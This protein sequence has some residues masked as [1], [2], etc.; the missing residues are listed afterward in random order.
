[1]MNYSHMPEMVSRPAPKTNRQLAPETL[2]GPTRDPTKKTIRISRSCAESMRKPQD[3]PHQPVES[4]KRTP[5]QT[6]ASSSAALLPPP[7]AGKRSEKISRPKLGSTQSDIL[8]VPDSPR[9]QRT[10]LF[11]SLTDPKQSTSLSSSSLSPRIQPSLSKSIQRIPKLEKTSSR[12]RL[13]NHS[14]KP[15]DT[16]SSNLR[17]QRF[18]EKESPKLD[19]TY[20]TQ[21]V[22]QNALGGH[23]KESDLRPLQ[24]AHRMAMGRQTQQQRFNAA[25]TGSVIST[26]ALTEM[27]ANHE[28]TDMLENEQVPLDWEDNMTI[29]SYPRSDMPSRH[30]QHHVPLHHNNQS[31]QVNNNPPTNSHSRDRTIS[32]P[33]RHKLTLDA[34]AKHGPAEMPR[35]RTLSMPQKEKPREQTRATQ[36]DDIDPLEIYPSISN[37]VRPRNPDKLPKHSRTLGDNKS[38]SLAS[39]SRPARLGPVKTV[40]IKI[41]DTESD[42]SASHS[43]GSAIFE[44]NS[45]ENG[46]HTSGDSSLSNS[47]TDAC[48]AID[49]RGPSQKAMRTRIEERSTLP[50]PLQPSPSLSS[51]MIVSH[52]AVGQRDSPKVKARTRSIQYDT[53]RQSAHGL[54]SSV[55]SSD[56]FLKRHSVAD[57]REWNSPAGSRGTTTFGSPR[58]PKQRVPEVRPEVRPDARL[59]QRLDQRLDSKKPQKVSRF[60]P[61]SNRRPSNVNTKSVTESAKEVLADIR[62]RRQV[63]EATK[64]QLDAERPTVGASESTSASKQTKPN[65]NLISRLSMRRKTVVGYETKRHSTIDTT[66]HMALRSESLLRKA[67]HPKVI[68]PPEQPQQYH[69]PR[70][71]DP[72]QRLCAIDR[73]SERRHSSYITSNPLE[74]N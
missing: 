52:I 55:G 16:A 67:R 34:L 25:D 9:V 43:G 20:K 22:D 32:M 72:V 4:T 49:T 11:R 7:V 27:L 28:T 13:L 10:V 44:L 74:G 61:E 59:D 54:Q 42:S 53:Q 31:T 3:S 40:Q 36:T 47:P 29:R 15:S 66:E 51:Q 8:R 38:G 24:H 60:A 6:I 5:S 46:H 23:L 39:M 37:Q 35:P 63:S 30:L 45:P 21:R 2:S 48:K 1:M 19:G 68:V 73:V 56:L 33:E 57:T 41:Q 69:R 62:Q 18:Q 26:F 70:Q 12:D 71:P 17:H 64:Q 58:T 14:R 50:K 65:G